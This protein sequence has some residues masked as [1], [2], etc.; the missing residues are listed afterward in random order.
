MY[1]VDEIVEIVSRTTGHDFKI[2]E[3]VKV[4]SLDTLGVGRA[5]SLETGS[6]FYI[7]NK[8]IKKL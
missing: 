4:L 6:V 8:D 5:E 2:G 3:H 1:K 7:S